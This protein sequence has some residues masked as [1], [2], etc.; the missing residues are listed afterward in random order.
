M[1]GISQ[2]N[3]RGF[4]LLE[5]MVA[6]AILALSFTT[7]ALVQA[8]AT[9][10]AVQGRTISIATQLARLQLMECKREAQK[11]IASA[12]DFKKE[13]DFGDLGYENFKWEC[14]APKFNMKG[15][16]ASQ[17]DAAAKKK[18]PGAQEKNTGATADMMSPMM[19][20]ITDTLGNSVRE[21]VVI[22]RW[23]EGTVEDEMRV[24]THIIDLAA[25]GALAKMLKQG[26]DQL[27][28]ATGQKT[29]PATPSPPSSREPPR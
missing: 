8:R 26:A 29:A 16:S 23:T 20:I 21:L 18:A 7:L 28:K 19:S 5:V 14:H 13:G 27:G 15:P 3:L 25:M 24:V 22:V 9:N 17:I 1:K 11:Q 6:L 12:G 4:S 2:K 10:L